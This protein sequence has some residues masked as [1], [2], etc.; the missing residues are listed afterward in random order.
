MVRIVCV[1]GARPNF[2]KIKPVLDAL[3]ER[4]ADTV[5]VHTGQ[6][7]D[8]AM[9]DVFFGDLG[10]RAPDHTLAAG[11]GTHAEQTGVVMVGFEALLAKLAADAVVVVGDV[12]STLACAL[13]AAKAVVPVAHVESGLRSHDWAMPEEIN[14]ILTDRLTHWLLAPSPDAVENLMAEG[15]SPGRIHLIGNVMVDTLLA[16]V[17][18]ARSRPVLA[19]LGVAAGDFGLVTL[20]RPATVDQPSVL[21]PLM[22]ALSSLASDVPLVFPVHPRTR[23]RLDTGDLPASLLLVE[24]LGYLDF[25]GL[26]DAAG[27]VLTD[28]GGVQEE[29]TVLGTPC[30]TLRENTERPIT[31]TE[32]TNRLVGTDPQR[33]LEAARQVLAAPPPPRCPALWD[34]HAGPR[35]AEAIFDHP[36]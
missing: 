21:G 11:S 12:N 23:D 6:H 31:V 36:A 13:V 26:E 22:K 24:P 15:V 9:S 33:V 35:A 3:E 16:N 10:I 27:I 17:D 28:S 19:Y 34:G 29:T 32:G 8:A 1:V 7:Y 4:G 30:L 20:H 14:R 2:V 25:L 18:R 5:L